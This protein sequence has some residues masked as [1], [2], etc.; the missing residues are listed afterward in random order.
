LVVNNGMIFMTVFVKID[1]LVGQMIGGH[2]EKHA[3]HGDL[4]HQCSLRRKE[5]RL[6]IPAS[7]L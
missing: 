2:T 6:K 5:S 3:H 7:F 4:I 1:R